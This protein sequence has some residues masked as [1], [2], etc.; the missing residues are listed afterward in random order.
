MHIATTAEPTAPATA[1]LRPRPDQREVW[2]AH[3]EP[4]PFEEAAQRLLDAH[5]ED[6]ERDDVVV[7]DLRAWAFGPVQQSMAL[8][9]VPLPGRA[10]MAPVP[11]RDLAFTQLC[12]RIGAPAAYVRSLPPKLQIACMNHG[13]T[14]SRHAA[15][16]RLAGGEV[17]ALVGDRYAALDDER[18][19][20]EVAEVLDRA[21]YLDDARVRASAAGPHTLL[22]ITMP[23]EGV[24][25]KPGDVIEWGLDIGN[26]EVGLRSVQVTPVT[27]RL[28]CTN[29]MRSWKSEA[30][31]RM[32]HVGDPKRLREQLRD[33]IPVA[34]AEA[35]GDID[36][37]RR[38]T[39]VLIDDAL[40]EIENLRAFGLSQT[41]VAAVGRELAGTAAL[42]PA[43][44]SAET[45]DVVLD[46]PSTAYEIANAI[47]AVARD[48]ADVASRLTMEEVGHRYLAQRTA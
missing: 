13:L 20:D 45:L 42:L 37:W 35:R 1:P 6:G 28:V 38:A 10:P 24:A 26:S 47:T 23:G 15:L 44:S 19:L 46:R 40:D 9:P 39:E 4:V 34:F 5:A 18:V 2:L 43:N 25:V 31:M 32:R 8:A 30:A 48:R 29:G 41:E 21:G 16:L 27:Y 12:Q 7:H 22:R 14:Q 33:A 3:R 11:L 36:R 17:R